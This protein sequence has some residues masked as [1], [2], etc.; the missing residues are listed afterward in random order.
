MRT[1]AGGP[2]KRLHACEVDASKPLTMVRSR[3]ASDEEQYV[4]REQIERAKQ[5]LPGRMP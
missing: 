5:E 2:S 4:A 1:A 3:A